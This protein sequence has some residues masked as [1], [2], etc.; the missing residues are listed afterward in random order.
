MIEI[1]DSDVVRIGRIQR[2][3][4]AADEPLVRPGGSEGLPACQRVVREVTV[5]LVTSADVDNG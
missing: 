3:L 2:E 1:D 5:T 4:D